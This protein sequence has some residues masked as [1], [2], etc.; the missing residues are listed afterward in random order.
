MR[1]ENAVTIQRPAAEVFAY[2][3]DF[4]NVPAWN[5]AIV[6]T[7][8]TTEAS[9]GVGTTY[10]QVRKLPRPSEETFEVTEFEPPRR[11]SAEGTFGPFLGRFMYVLD[12]EGQGTRVT[13]VVE[14][15]PTG[16]L[17]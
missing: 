4:E 15:R 8:K 10:R 14:L 17:R 3:A 9:V 2:L 7:R 1:F 5:N 11:L 13:N 12:P 6:E 16:A